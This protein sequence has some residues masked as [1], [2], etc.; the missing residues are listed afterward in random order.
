MRK[1]A[2]VTF[3][4]ICFCIILNMMLA[5]RVYPEAGDDGRGF[6]SSNDMSSRGGISSKDFERKKKNQED[7]I[8]R[9]GDKEDLMQEINKKKPSGGTRVTDK[10]IRVKLLGTRGSGETV[11]IEA[12]GPVGGDGT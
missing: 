6:S 8:K 11:D 10:P 12:I 4:M 2:G 7:T 1:S 3:K 9:K 5:V